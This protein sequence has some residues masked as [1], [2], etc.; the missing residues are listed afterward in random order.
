[1]SHCHS[2]FPATLQFKTIPSSSF[3]NKRNLQLACLVGKFIT[4]NSRTMWTDDTYGKWSAYTIHVKNVA[5]GQVLKMPRHMA[6]QNGIFP[7]MNENG[8]II[9]IYGLKLYFLS[10]SAFTVVIVYWAVW[11]QYLWKPKYKFNSSTN[12]RFLQCLKKQ[13]KSY[14]VLQVF[15]FNITV[16]G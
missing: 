3:P 11:Y 2:N 1:M 6:T 7:K 16:T 9:N 12:M 14:Y 4:A 8:S 15:L 13:C 10:H 5:M